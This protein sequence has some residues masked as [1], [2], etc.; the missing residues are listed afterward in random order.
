LAAWEINREERNRV[1]GDG[2]AARRAKGQRE[3]FLSGEKI[4]LSSEVK[5]LGITLDK[6]LTWKKQL[7]K[8]INLA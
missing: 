4:Q 1:C 2:R 8:V 5:Y 7:H 3:K 6:G